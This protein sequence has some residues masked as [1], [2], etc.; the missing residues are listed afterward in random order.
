MNIQ[1]NFFGK[2]GGVSQE[3]KYKSLNCGPKSGDFKENIEKNREIVKKIFDNTNYD[4]LE[5]FF[6]NQTHSD[7]VFIVESK[8]DLSKFPEA[9]GIVTNLKNI[10]LA[11]TTADCTPI[12]FYDDANKV[13]ACCH[14]GWKGAYSNLMKNL[15]DIMIN[16]YSCDIRNIKIKIGPN[17][18]Q[19]SYQVQQDFYNQW[20]AQSKNFAQF[21]DHRDDGY[22]FDLT[23]SIIFK[24]LQIGVE[25]KN[26]ENYDI[27]TFINENYFSYRRMIKTELIKN[28][29][30]A[31][32]V[33]TSAIAILEN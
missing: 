11:I 14:A 5:L 10:I 28:G 6:A 18:K 32:G 3:E 8:D 13:I 2:N 19:N 21:F 29:D 4:K 30:K 27:D 31:F 25:R 16:Q 20:I 7:K 17:I 15:I 12:L 33:N 1:F 23:N 22:Y 24:L 9:D 26:I